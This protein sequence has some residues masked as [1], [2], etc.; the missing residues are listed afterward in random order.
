MDAFTR[1]FIFIPLFLLLTGAN[2]VSSNIVSSNNGDTTKLH[3]LLTASTITPDAVC[4]LSETE[5]CSLK[6]YNVGDIIQV[7]I[8]ITD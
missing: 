7:L 3:P 4:T 5:D 6:N 2:I 1:R 8:K